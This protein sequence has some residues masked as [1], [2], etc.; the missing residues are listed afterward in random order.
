MTVEEQMKEFLEMY[1]DI[2]P[3]PDH[4]PKEYEYYVK[5]YKYIKE[6]DAKN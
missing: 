1:G 5:L 2:L 3:D 6:L 4:C